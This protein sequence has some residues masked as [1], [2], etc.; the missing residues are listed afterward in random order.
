MIFVPG[1]AWLH[2]TRA[3]QGYALMAH[4]AAQGWVCLSI[5][6]RVSPHH[7]WPRHI[8]DVKAAV[9]WARANVDRFGGD[10]DF[11]TIAGTSA[12]GGQ[13]MAAHG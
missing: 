7:R 3:L 10:R 9:A 2:G 11:V 6:Y 12:G 8:N 1:G 4:L 13:P 5:G